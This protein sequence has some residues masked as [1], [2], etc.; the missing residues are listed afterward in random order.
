MVSP[1]SAEQSN[2]NKQT[3]M[4]AKN[5]YFIANRNKQ[6]MFAHWFVMV[7]TALLRPIFIVKGAIV[8]EGHK[9]IKSD[10][11]TRRPPP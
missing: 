7:L 4:G 10:T 6:C 11:R 1:I 9:P 8:N 3:Q 5:K 2:C